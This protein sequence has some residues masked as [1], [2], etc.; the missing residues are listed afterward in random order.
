M[1]RPLEQ[2]SGPSRYLG[3]YLND[4]LA[5][6]AVGVGVARRLRQ[7]N[8]GDA[9]LAR[10]LADVCAEIEADR[11]T[12]EELMEH[13]GIRRGKLKPALAA[14]GE[15]L[16]RLKPNGQLTGYSPLSRLVELELLAVGVTGKMQLWDALGHALGERVGR[17]DFAALAARAA[18]QRETIAGLQLDAASRALSTG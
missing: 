9:A 17:F 10:P 11:A 13:L 15:R 5:G 16:G 2:S 3:I 6:A 1:P 14:V 12:L 8:A 4:H 18:R 7:S